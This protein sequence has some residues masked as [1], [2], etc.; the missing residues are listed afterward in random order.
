MLSVRSIMTQDVVTIRPEAPIYEAMTLLTRHEVSGLPVVEEDS[1]L[2][3]ILTE[4]DL[5]R[6]LLDMDVG[7]RDTVEHYMTKNVVSFSEDDSAITICQFFIRNPIRR[8]PITKNG[9]LIGVVSRRDII[10]LIIDAKSKLSEMR[11]S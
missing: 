3:G 7:V 2:V 4:K 1:T 5:L 8:V 9:K 6:L 11:F 10:L